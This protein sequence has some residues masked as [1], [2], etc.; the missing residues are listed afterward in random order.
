MSSPGRS[1]QLSRFCRT[2]RFEL[3]RPNP[4]IPEHCRVSE[5]DAGHGVGFVSVREAKV[6]EY[7]GIFCEEAEAALWWSRASSRFVN[8]VSPTREMGSG[9]ELKTKAQSKIST[10]KTTKREDKASSTARQSTNSSIKMQ[11][12]FCL[13][14]DKDS[15]DLLYSWAEYATVYS[16]RAFVFTSCINN[17]SCNL[18]FFKQWE[19]IFDKP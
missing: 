10:A 3:R 5:P 1:C 4:D 11:N 15:W 12:R 14:T 16:I 9:D 6:S 17:Q 2:V 13:L 18:F 19:W 7:Q 8:T